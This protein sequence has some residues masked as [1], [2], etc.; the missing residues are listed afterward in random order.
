MRLLFRS[1]PLNRSAVLSL[2][3]LC[4]GLLLIVLNP[5]GLPRPIDRAID[6]QI[7]P[8][9]PAAPSPTPATQA[10]FGKDLF[11]LYCMPCHGD[12]GQ[13]LTDEFRTRQYP[14][15]D[16]NCW[17]SGCHGDRPYDHGFTLPKV[18]PALI[19]AGTLTRFTT[20]QDL[21][22]FISKAMPFNNPGSLSQAQYLQLATYLL[23]SNQRVTANVQ[24]D[25][26]ALTNIAVHDAVSTATPAP[27]ATSPATAELP[28]AFWG[29][30]IFLIV[31][32]V[33]SI[34]TR[35]RK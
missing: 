11:W 15:E 2:S 30:L 6:L 17:K 21:Y 19:G 5:I 14:T 16:Q 29:I 18:I 4:F 34:A 26:S 3:G 12:L 22:A 7:T 13:G 32:T 25:P 27:A 33:L 1:R 28:A 10:G 31:A 23:A 9:S 24:L 35:R 20:A 8:T